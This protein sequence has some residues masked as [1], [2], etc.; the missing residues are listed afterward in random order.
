MKINKTDEF[1]E[2]IGHYDN[3]VQ[4]AKMTLLADLYAIEHR[5]GYAKFPIDCEDKLGLVDDKLEFPFLPDKYVYVNGV[6]YTVD[7]GSTGGVSSWGA[8]IDDQVC[9]SNFT[10]ENQNILFDGEQLQ[11]NG[12]NV[13]RADEIIFDGEYTTASTSKVSVDLTTLAGWSSLTGGSHNI[14]IVAKADGY[15]DSEPSAA[16]SV[17]KQGGG[18]TVTPKLT[19]G[20]WRWLTPFD[21]ARYEVLKDLENNTTVTEFTS[22]GKTFTGFEYDLQFGSIAYSSD[23]EYVDVIVGDAEYVNET[24]KDITVT[25]D[26]DLDEADFLYEDID[27]E[28]LTKLS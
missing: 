27:M 11:Y 3:E 20:T 28:L 5:E 13:V 18:G 14:T 21:V 17:T 10:F 9:E 25:Q 4:C 16:V 1:I 15:A 12:V 8:A 7:N 6:R 2:V 26:F 23:T 24:Y 22:G 19:K